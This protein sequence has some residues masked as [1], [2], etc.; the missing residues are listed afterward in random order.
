MLKVHSA[1]KALLFAVALLGILFVSVQLFKGKST[2]LDEMLKKVPQLY[3][4]NE[5]EDLFSELVRDRKNSESGEE[6]KNEIGAKGLAALGFTYKRQD[7]ETEMI[8]KLSEMT[9]KL[10]DDQEKRINRLEKERQGLERQLERLRRPSDE[11]SLREKLSFL[12]PFDPNAKFPGY[13]WQSWK[14]G[15]NDERFGDEYSKCQSKWPGKN[16]GFVH[17][18]FNDDTSSAFIHFLYLNVPDVTEAFD[19]L[20]NAVLK[21]EFFR[22]LILYA[23]GGVWADIDTYPV[24]PIPNWIPENVEPSELGM[25]IGVDYDVE[26]EA[27]EDWRNTR[28]RKFQFATGVMQAK[29]GH[30]ILREVIAA[31]TEE[32][33]QKKRIHQLQLPESGRDIALMEWT[34][35][36]VFTDISLRFFNDYVLSGVFSKVT[37]KDFHELEVPKLVSDVLVMPKKALMSPFMENFDD[38]EDES[39]PMVMVRHRHAK[40]YKESW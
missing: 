28:A 33:L 39:D 10:V 27:S 35:E 8:K 1:R 17:E 37:W 18:I 2:S 19:A 11:L 26:G 25:I 5:K 29:P 40:I 3:G 13:I 15:L 31:I 9:Q 21:V 23:K 38:N 6:Q 12:Y 14:Y 34:G 30:P 4:N 36:G 24:R 22:Y 20:P 7:E 32:T 16:P